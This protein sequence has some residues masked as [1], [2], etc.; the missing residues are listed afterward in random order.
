MGV[1]VCLLPC[2]RRDGNRGSVQLRDYEAELRAREA[3]KA[4]AR[5]ATRDGDSTG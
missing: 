3:V 4:L 1:N 2:K 5:K